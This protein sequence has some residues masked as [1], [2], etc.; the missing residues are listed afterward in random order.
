[1]KLTVT[2]IFAACLVLESESCDIATIDD[3]ENNGIVI[4]CGGLAPT[5]DAD[6]EPQVFSSSFTIIDRE[7]Q[8]WGFSAYKP[9]ALTNGV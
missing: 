2:D 1:M 8:E 6:V 7:G 5:F 4:R 9:F 3:A